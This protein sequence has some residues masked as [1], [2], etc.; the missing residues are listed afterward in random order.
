MVAGALF[1][2]PSALAQQGT[3]TSETA[4]QLEQQ[5]IIHITKDG[6]NSY[7]IS[8]GSSNIGTFDTSYRIVG[9]RSA[10]RASE[11]LIITTITED[12][13]RSPTI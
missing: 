11:E 12:F 8:G 4:G 6:T 7:L 9:E 10:V 13:R 1:T 2:A 5:T 3:S